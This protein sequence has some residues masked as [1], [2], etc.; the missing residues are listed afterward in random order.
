[1]LH[2][3][4]FSRPRPFGNHTSPST[5]IY[6]D[7]KNYLL[8]VDAVGFNKE[9]I[10]ISATEST[11]SLEAK[12]DLDAPEGYKPLYHYPKERNIKRSFRFRDSIE[13]DGIQANVE[14]GL[15]NI[16]IPKKSAKTIEVHIQ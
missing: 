1:M 2:S 9:D 4:F 14:N 8:Q 16:I 13:T 10:K 3:L 5:D 12:T 15:L 6:D 11:L 7:G